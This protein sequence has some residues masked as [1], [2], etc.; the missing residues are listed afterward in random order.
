MI[1]LQAVDSLNFLEQ[2]LYLNKHLIKHHTLPR[3]HCSVLLYTE[4]HIPVSQSCSADKTLKLVFPLSERATETG[5]SAQGYGKN[6]GKIFHYL[7]P[8]THTQI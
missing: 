6:E 1:N 7:C 5:Q 3:M 4:Q 2:A 8:H